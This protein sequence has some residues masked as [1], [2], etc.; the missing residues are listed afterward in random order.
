MFFVCGVGIDVAGDVRRCGAT[1]LD[2]KIPQRGHGRVP[3]RSGGQVRRRAEHR[4][5][6]SMIFVVSV[7]GGAVVTVRAVI[8]HVRVDVGVIAAIGVTVYSLVP[9]SCYRTAV[10]VGVGE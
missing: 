1:M 4:G 9:G 10:G 7:G 3:R 6:C 8:A 5:W 2:G